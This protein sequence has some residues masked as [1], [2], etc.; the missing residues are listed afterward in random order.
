M[1]HETV[2]PVVSVRHT[3]VSSAQCRVSSHFPLSAPH[4]GNLTP[5]VP[6]K[7]PPRPS[8][9]ASTIR[10]QAD[11]TQVRL[12]FEA[13]QAQQSPP[14]CHP[15]SPL[16]CAPRRGSSAAPRRGAGAGGTGAP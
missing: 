15:L 10:S 9:A 11:L 4:H 6:S 14:R 5:K 7:T 16:G 2:L 8:V 12:E 13:P 1:R 3:L